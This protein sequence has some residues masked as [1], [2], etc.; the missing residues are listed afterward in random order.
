MSTIIEIA[1]RV[2]VE[3]GLSVA[4]I[5]GGAFAR[6]QL[7]ELHR[8]NDAYSRTKDPGDWEAYCRTKAGFVAGKRQ[9]RAAEAAKD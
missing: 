2:A 7:R 1:E 6:D 8:L 4:D 5:D 9:E 3:H